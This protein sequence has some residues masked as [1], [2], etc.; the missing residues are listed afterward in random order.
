MYE[1]LKKA[2]FSSVGLLLASMSAV[3]GLPADYRA[4]EW[5]QGTG[6]QW[7]NTEYTPDCTDKVE[8][9]VQ[10][11]RISANECLY[12]SRGGGAAA[13]FT[14]FTQSDHARLRFDRNSSVDFGYSADNSLAVDGIY[15]VT[16]DGNTR[17]CTINGVSVTKMVFAGEYV[18]VG[19][20]TLFCAHTDGANPKNP[21]NLSQYRLFHFKVTDKEG[22]VKVHLV[23]CVHRSNEKV[24]LYDLVRN[25]FFENK[26]SGSFATSDAY[27]PSALPAG[28]TRL[29][30]IKSPGGPWIDTGYTPA[31]TDRVELKVQLASL[32][33][34]ECLYCSRNK[35]AVA[36]FT[37][38][39]QL[40]TKNFRFDRNNNY[41]YSPENSLATGVDYEI[42]AD[43]ATLDCSVNG[44]VCAKMPS[45]AFTPS[46]SFTLFA[47]STV[48]DP[49][50]YNLG[51]FRLY[52][53]RVRD[54]TG[55]VKADLVPCRQESNQAVGMYDLKAGRFLPNSGSGT[56][57]CDTTRV[58]EWTGANAGGSWSTAGNWQPSETPGSGKVLLFNGAVA[59]VQDMG[60]V[61]VGGLEFAGDGPFSVT[62]AGTVTVAGGALALRE[63][64]WTTFDV[65]LSLTG[66]TE[67]GGGGFV[68]GAA[69]QKGVQCGGTLILKGDGEFV[70]SGVP[71]SITGT[72]AFTSGAGSLRFDV[73]G[74]TAAELRLSGDRQ[75]YF[76]AD[77]AFVGALSLGDAAANHQGVY[78]L[79]G[80]NQGGF[81]RFDTAM[82]EALAT[83]VPRITSKTPA[84]ITLS[85]SEQGN[86]LVQADFL[87]AA[88][89]CWNPTDGTS[90]LTL[91]NRVQTTRG[92][93]IVSNGTVRLVAG[94]TFTSLAKL[95]VAAGATLEIASDAG[96][97]FAARELEIAEGGILSLANGVKL[98]FDEAKVLNAAGV[99]TYLDLGETYGS[100][101]G[102]SSVRFFAGIV[103]AGTFDVKPASGV[104]TYTTWD[105][106]GGA[107]RSA[108]LAANW[109]E[110]TLPD[111]R[112][113]GLFAMFAAG[114]GVDVNTLMRM[115]GCVV[116]NTTGDFAFAKVGDN[117][118]TVFGGGVQ[119]QQGASARTL[120]FSVPVKVGAS[121][122]WTVE[123][124]NDALRLVGGLSGSDGNVLTIT[125]NGGATIAGD[126]E[127][128]GETVFA[129]TRGSQLTVDSARMA[130]PLSLGTKGPTLL[131]KGAVSFDGLV[132]VPTSGIYPTFRVTD[133]AV[134]TG[135]LEMDGL[136]YL[137][138]N[139]TLVITNRPVQAAAINYLYCTEPATT[140]LWAEGNAAH[141]FHY[142]GGRLRC[143]VPLA[144][145]GKG[146]LRIGF[147]SYPTDARG[148]FEMVGEQRVTEFLT[149]PTEYGVGGQEVFS[150]TH[151]VLEFA[152]TTNRDC[153]AS[154]RGGASLR[155]AGKFETVICTPS[156]STGTVEV[157]A[158]TLVFDTNRVDMVDA[159]PIASAGGSWPSASAVVVGGRTDAAV[160]ELR[161]RNT[162]GE[163][164]V[165]DVR[166]NG[167]IRIADGVRE[168]VGELYLNGE[169]QPAGTYGATTSGASRR[170]DTFFD[171]AA[172][173][174]IC[175]G[176]TGTLLIF[177]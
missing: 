14:C 175:V 86:P 129:P 111:L 96:A 166:A 15:T 157:V 160:L 49:N 167:K 19:P 44:V 25:R 50:K 56:F 110:D 77:D 106:D 21:A 42:V 76:N 17:D 148:W 93:L 159:S 138:G 9:K 33:A 90:V 141:F 95:T 146:R 121:Q 132:K 3:A 136:M 151:S 59:S 144:L 27:E 81:T 134:C 150:A 89:L 26:G 140:E 22:F 145:N 174:V 122:T 94:A 2:V 103:G 102:V 91:S 162:F 139:G 128:A 109:T 30:W 57:S 68:S 31:G 127:F 54:T 158:G 115:N 176:V 123:G 104:T 16:A 107:D 12:C 170:S 97:G 13:T 52:Y 153:Y 8:T 24:G 116:S 164:T 5:I 87:G 64:S 65:P 124:T 35:S 133:R 147:S 62:G 173:G 58:L 10:L 46:R 43:G 98:T 40:A 112:N 172:R 32:G 75:V 69:F 73:G 37:C 6:S 29:T 80:H 155:H 7:I 74:N 83:P 63:R 23:P 168:K 34:N 137:S 1:V 36:T 120:T 143:M 177:R 70:F 82:N 114:T 72:L 20:F 161:H 45:G 66:A 55:A 28:Y 126:T 61:T 165:L 125:G 108:N 105:A 149:S 79:C 11:T 163:A 171:P 169:R 142:Y 88:G 131:A 92:E 85:G 51:T 113:G 78:D 156:D 101:E 117:S 118:L 135:G 48:D 18:P 53:F 152:N 4:L 60:A 71:S 41:D 100:S 84:L 99:A 38:F 130:G 119:L 67:L 47:A 39:T 154:F